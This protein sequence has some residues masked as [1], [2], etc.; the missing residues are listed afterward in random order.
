MS[1]LVLQPY[2]A[3]APLSL[4]GAQ[5]RTNTL[6]QAAHL[7]FDGNTGSLSTQHL[8]IS[9]YHVVL[10]RHGRLLYDAMVEVLVQRISDP[11]TKEERK[12]AAV[13]MISD[14]VSYLDKN[15]CPNAGALTIKELGTRLIEARNAAMSRNLKRVELSELSAVIPWNHTVDKSAVTVLASLQLVHSLPQELCCLVLDF[16][17][18]PV[19]VSSTP[20][21]TRWIPIHL[22]EGPIMIQGLATFCPAFQNVHKLQF[23][24]CKSFHLQC[25]EMLDLRLI[26]SWPSLKFV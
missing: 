24:P 26:L 10:H 23:P 12:P 20:P 11:N 4:E 9:G 5:Q 17:C 6:T 2:T 16:L 7:C 15:W 1:K 3:P 13:S 21:L 25:T 18:I 8:Y 19:D 14:L 22:G